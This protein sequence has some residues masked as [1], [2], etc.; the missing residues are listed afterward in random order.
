MAIAICFIILVL[1]IGVACILL[2]RRYSIWSTKIIRTRLRWL[3]NIGFPWW[4]PSERYVFWGL[5]ITGLLLML[6]A[7]VFTLLLIIS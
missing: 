4:P 7:L 6:A 1:I 3:L 5:R 2:A